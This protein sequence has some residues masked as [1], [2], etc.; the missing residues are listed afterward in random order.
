[1]STASR[2]TFVGGDGAEIV[3]F[4]WEPAGPVRAVVQ[5]THG[6]GEYVRRYEHVAAA[7]VARGYAVQGQDHRA[8]GAT[9]GSEGELGKLG[10]N[11]WS[12]LV[13]DIGV[14]A[15][16]GR[17]RWPGVPLVLLSHSLG[18]FATQ[19]F[20]L[21]SSDR[22]DAVVL[23]GTSLLDLLEPVMDLDADVDLS[24]FN[25]P[26]SPARNGFDWLSRDNGTVDAYLGDPYCGFGLDP[27]GMKAMFLGARAVADPARLAQVRFDLP[28]HVAV[29]GADP[30]GGQAMAPVLVDRYRAAGLTEVTLRVYPDARHEIL[31][32]TN[33]DE[34]VGDIISW[35]DGVVSRGTPHA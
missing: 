33:A 23:T 11:G 20:L 16:C 9:A 1:M 10:A 30:V 35:I 8:H 7:L 25:A 4:R 22:V 6:L 18:S 19:Q 15:Q 26:F 29:G 34:V 31:N 3:A 14:L 32:E 12:E 21:D 24:M 27:E 17:A 13:R 2:F 28:L 5:I